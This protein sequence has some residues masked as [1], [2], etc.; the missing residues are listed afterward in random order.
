MSNIISTSDLTSYMQGKATN[1]S[2][3]QQVVDAVNT[4][5]ETRTHRCWGETK[6]VTDEQYAWNSVVWLRRTDIVSVDAVKLGW[7]GQT[8]STVDPSAYYL[9]PLGR[10]TFYMY[11]NPNMSRLYNDYLHISY[12]HGYHEG[13]KDDGTPNLVVPDDLQL[14]AL[15][16]AANF[17]NWAANG[18]KDVVSAALGSYRLEYSGAVRSSGQ[19]NPATNTA[20]ANW[21]VVDSY[22]LQRA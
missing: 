7:P 17:Y 14:A 2:L 10:L 4:Y 1:T 19:P 15:G 11:A 6:T 22:R 8:Q 3:A 21:A 9:N 13:F 18:N 5:V 16:I 12:T 20:E